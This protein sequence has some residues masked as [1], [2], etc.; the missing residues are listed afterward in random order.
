M[1]NEL[2]TLLFDR[3]DLSLKTFS[4]EIIEDI[5][6]D[7]IQ[8]YEDNRAFEVTGKAMVVAYSRAIAID[9]YKKCPLGLS[10]ATKNKVTEQIVKDALQ[11]KYLKLRATNDIIGIE[12]CSSIKNKHK[13]ELQL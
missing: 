1:K 2:G 12:I 8:H 10:L 13:K 4:P 7:I 5:C 9:M 11:N 6:T 3:I